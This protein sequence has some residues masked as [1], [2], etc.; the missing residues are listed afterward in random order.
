MKKHKLILKIKKQLGFTL[1]ELT[2]ALALTGLVGTAIASTV[3]QVYGIHAQTMASV[4]AQDQV[5]FAANWINSDAQMAQDIVRRGTTGLPVSFKWEKWDVVA[6]P[7]VAKYF[8]IVY[9]LADNELKREEI[10]KNSNGF[11]IYDRTTTVA[12]YIN[13]DPDKTFCTTDALYPDTF[14]FQITATVGSYRQS[15]ATA[16][17]RVALRN[18]SV[19]QT[20]E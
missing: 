17:V 12:R 5:G 2:I 8:E 18:A 20:S 10:Q 15:T 13:A 19:I 6:D 7:N 11:P 16:L 1:I 9:S 4:M 3:F 14:R